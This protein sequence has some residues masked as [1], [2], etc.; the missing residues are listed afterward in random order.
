MSRRVLPFALL[1]ACTS[2]AYACSSKSAPSVVSLP[3]DDGGPI[4]DTPDT[5]TAPD[6]DGGPAQDSGGDGATTPATP[7][8]GA[9][10]IQ[11]ADAA[12]FA[13]SPKWRTTENVLYVALPE[14]LS[15]AGSLVRMGADGSNS[16]LVR[17]G[18]GVTYGTWGNAIDKDGALINAERTRIVKTTNAADG[19]FVD[20]A[21]GWGADGG[22]PF[23]TPR[24]LVARP[25]DNAIFFTDPGYAVTTPAANHI[26]R[27]YSDGGVA[28]IQ[29]FLAG[30][31]L[32]RPNGLVLSKDEHTLFVS[33]T[34]L[35]AGPKP[36]IQ[37][38]TVAADGSLSNGAKFAE[39]GQD[40]FAE[41]LAIDDDENV[42]VAFKSGI[43]VY[44]KDGTLWGA[45]PSIPIA[46]K[47]NITGVG[48]GA[49][50]R[51]TLFATTDTGRILSMQVNVAGVVN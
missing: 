23:D 49:A 31:D 10:P 15:G 32:P 20:I 17:V 11:I 26:F 34:E 28:M 46:G 19:G 14:D 2:W 37:K 39:L 25:S 18:D 45:S 7:F 29:E 13:T 5:G 43:N 21:T 42:Y 47:G 27:S 9:M 4:L 38:Y 24:N 36:H 48:F 40:D 6:E 35:T 50:D 8:E 3:G 30:P 51:K 33:F 44:K 12:Q 16:M 41:G 22:V 1:L